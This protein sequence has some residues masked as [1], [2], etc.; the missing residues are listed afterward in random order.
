MRGW[1]SARRTRAAL[2]LRQTPIFSIEERSPP[3]SDSRLPSYTRNSLT[4][5]LIIEG[6]Q[7]IVDPQL[8]SNA[9]RA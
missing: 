3:F 5:A 9:S 4:E 2:Q 8:T 7:Q 6:L 1:E